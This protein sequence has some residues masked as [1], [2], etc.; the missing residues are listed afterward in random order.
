MLYYPYCVCTVDQHN[1]AGGDCLVV[2]DFSAVHGQ[3][4]GPYEDRAAAAAGISAG[5][6]RS[7]V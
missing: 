1:P 2:I 7:V 5:Q 4:T 6:H 3:D